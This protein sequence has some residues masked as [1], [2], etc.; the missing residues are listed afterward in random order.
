MVATSDIRN[1]YVGADELFV[2]TNKQN[3]I[4]TDIDAFAISAFETDYNE[5]KI[6][7]VYPKATPLLQF[8]NK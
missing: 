5:G 6:L 2:V 3:C 8:I 4:E 7:V 1:Y